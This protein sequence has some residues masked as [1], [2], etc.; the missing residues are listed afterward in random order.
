VVSVGNISQTEGQ[1]HGSPAPNHEKSAADKAVERTAT[2]TVWIALFTVVLAIVGAI[3]LYEVI[4]GGTDTHDLAVQAKNQADAAKTL[5]LAAG[6]QADVANQTMQV[7][8]RPWM[9]I[10]VGRAAM[11]DGRPISIPARIVNSGK[12]P[13]FNVQGFAVVNLLSGNAQPDFNYG[14]GV[15]PKY[16]FGTGTA[17]PNVAN[18][19]QLPVLPTYV[20][21]SKPIN[22]ILATSEIRAGI[23][24]GTLYIA[25]YG[26][27]TY[28]DIFGTD[29]WINFC[30]YTQRDGAAISE[31]ATADT[32]GPYNDVDKNYQ[33]K[34]QQH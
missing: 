9:N 2:A 10:T 7:D 33:Q 29:H 25:V 16:S 28:A 30:S 1:P 27:I 12:T 23:Q 13:A 19:Q 11:I 21:R 20:P 15:H 3:T 17:I 4:A 22:P 32:C 34:K 18:D 31:K 26:R 24:D 5:A 14:S 8:Q 6:T